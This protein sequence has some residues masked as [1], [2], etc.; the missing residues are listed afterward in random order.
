MTEIDYKYWAFISYSHR[1]EAWAASLH[2][3]LETYHVPRALR[4]KPTATGTVPRRLFPIFRDRDE[5][6]GAADLGVKIR[7]ALEQSRHL[8]VICSPNSAASP[9]VNQE[10][11]AF[12]ALGRDDRVLCFIVA[13]EPH[14]SE[15]P[16]NASQECFP[17]AARF[18]VGSSGD[19][20]DELAEPLAADARKGKDG[21]ANAVLKLMAGMLEVGFDDLK[22]REKLRKRRR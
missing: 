20:I 14:A 13:G 9:W 5:L 10:I 3:K 19:L 2:R 21:A 16:G 8:I 15:V 6:A 11:K 1:D 18:R 17:P 22:Q 4:G 12:K 7:R